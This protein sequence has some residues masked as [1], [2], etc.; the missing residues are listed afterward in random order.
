MSSSASAAP[1]LSLELRPS[2]RLQLGLGLAHAGALALLLLV[3]LPPWLCLP[4]AGL[5]VA[6]LWRELVR[7]GFP[8]RALPID[9]LI[10]ESAGRWWL[11]TAHGRSEQGWLLPDSFVHP[12]LVV[13]GFRTAAGR[14]RVVILPDMAHPEAL[15]QLRV[16]LRLQG[17]ASAAGPP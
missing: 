8:D 14:R 6:S 13:L 9:A 12:Q 5:V 4:G 1:T 10:W 11:R 7:A 2:R 3:D 15:R 16:R 17:A